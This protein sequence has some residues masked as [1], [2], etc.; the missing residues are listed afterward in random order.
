[1]V[2]NKDSFI[3][4]ENVLKA[5]IAEAYPAPAAVELDYI[6]ESFEDKTEADEFTEDPKGGY[7]YD[8]YRE[9]SVSTWFRYLR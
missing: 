5:A 1:M 8:G 7:E 2:L 9:Y 3:E 4:D 6:E